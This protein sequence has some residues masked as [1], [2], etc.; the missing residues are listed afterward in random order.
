MFVAPYCFPLRATVKYIC[1]YTCCIGLR[2]YYSNVFFADSFLSS[3]NSHRKI[4]SKN[5]I[6]AK[7][8]KP[9]GFV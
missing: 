9:T 1:I 7:V 4:I 8:L 5:Q 6:V 2:L 3:L